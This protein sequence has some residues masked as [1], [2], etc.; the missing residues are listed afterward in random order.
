MKKVFIPIVFLISLSIILFVVFT[1]A[2]AKLLSSNEALNIGEEKYLKFLWMVD[3]A[4][5]NDRLKEE[6]TVNDKKLSNDDKVFVCKYKKKNECIGNNFESEFSK[7][8]SKNIDYSK[9]YSDGV[10]YSWISIKDG[11]YIFNNLNSCSINRMGINHIL[12]VKKILS[13]KII[14]EVE[15]TNRGANQEMKRSFELILED[16][17]WKINYAFYYDLCGMWYTIR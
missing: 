1:K 9:V 11:E 2:N 5:N 13:D 17:E 6:F 8:F 4:F 16:N 15:F 7:L 12:K 3:G 14:Y 10:T